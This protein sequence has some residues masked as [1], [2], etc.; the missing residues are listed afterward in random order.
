V[1]ENPVHHAKND[2]RYSH[3]PLGPMN[4]LT[5]YDATAY[6]NWRSMKEAL[7]MCY[8]PNSSGKYAEGMKI[9]PEAL[10]L[11]GYRLPTEAE[12][13]YAC[14]AGAVTSRPYGTSR[15]LLGRYAWYSGTS[16]DHAWPCRSLLPNDLGL[17]DMLGNV[18]EWCQ[19]VLQRYQT[20]L[21]MSIRDDLPAQSSVDDSSRRVLRGGVFCKQPALVRSASRIWYEPTDNNDDNGLRLVRTLP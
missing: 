21:T 3:D 14:R 5:W 10:R 4:C 15:G 18:C 1:N 11:G 6:C 8:E 17:F 2:D 9:K 13:E 12:W 20:D 7:P 19:D 16:D